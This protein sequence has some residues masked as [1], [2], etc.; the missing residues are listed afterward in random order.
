MEPEV[1]H[2]IVCDDVR[3]DPHNFHRLDVRGIRIRLRVRQKPPLRLDFCFLAILVGFRGTGKLKVRIVEYSSRRRIAETPSY[4]VTYPRV[5]SEVVTAVFRMGQCN[6]PQLG[7]YRVEL[8]D[9]SVVLR[10]TP[11]WLLP[12][13]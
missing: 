13:E 7:R 12:Q 10:Q 9:G 3:A 8:I 2:F 1:I 4:L 11:F 5:P 6:L